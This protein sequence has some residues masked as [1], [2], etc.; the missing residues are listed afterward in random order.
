MPVEKNLLTVLLPHKERPEYTLRW[1][2]Y[3]E[4]TKFPFTVIIADGSDDSN[5][6][7][8]LL[9][10]RESYP[11]IDLVYMRYPYDAS[12]SEYY[13]KMVSV[14][15]TIT[16]PFLALV[17][18]DILPVV[19]GLKKSVHFLDE[20]EDYSTC[21]GQHLDFIFDTDNREGSLLCG[22]RMRIHSL[23][24]DKRHTIW[25]SFEDDDPLVR[26]EQWSHCINILYYNVHR[27]GNL[28]EAWRFI[29]EQDCADIFITDLVIAL[30]MADGY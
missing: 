25:R 5:I 20:N 27:T 3:A 2:E 13:T 18:N 8:A 10:P 19:E 24:F 4:E 11:D 16:T 21:R 28:V 9:S 14:I 6:E 23:Y 29:Q 12:Y 22:D 15:S 17:D 30:P 26:I 7:Q 1:L